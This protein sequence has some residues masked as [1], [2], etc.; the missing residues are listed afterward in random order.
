MRRRLSESSAAAGPPTLGAVVLPV[1]SSK[2][3]HFSLGG[4]PVRVEPAFFVIIAILGYNP[5]R[6]SLPGVLWWIAI[7]FVSIL[8][9]ELGHA[10][11]FRIYGLRPS[12]TLH[13]LGGL[14]SGSGELSPVRHII[15]SL[16]GP[17]SALLL[18]GVP[19]FLLAQSDAITSIEGRDAVD[20]AV[21]INIGWSL[22]NLLPVLPLDGGQVFASAVDI[23]TRGRPT[24][25]PEIVSI[26][27]AA[28]L[29][30]VAVAAGVYFGAL[31]AVM[32]AAINISALSR[33]KRE[34][35]GVELQQVHRLLLG[36]RPAEAEAAARE[37]LAKRPSA[38]V[39]RWASELLAWSLLWQ[40]DVNGAEQAVLRYAHAGQPSSSFRAAQALASARTNEG[41][42][43][44]AWALANEPAGPAKSLAAV[45]A[46]GSGQALAVSHE[47]LLLGPPG[48][49][50]NDLFA[51]LLDYAGYQADATAVKQLGQQQPH[52]WN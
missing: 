48:A 16:A 34:D 36:H 50:A 21:W 30:L 4:I 45:A 32:F 6:P 46:A 18:L 35:L 27:V 39:L 29:A 23:G 12:I 41:V 9:H 8:V 49:R 24:R 19:S 38:D 43:M 26:V 17:L 2:R 1:P 47:L 51:Q 33:R 42:T 37:V 52:D 10:V 11:A 7:A 25:L 13:G 40:G 31:I 20:A 14:T 3:S 5:Y 22:L 44:L 28:L 15:V